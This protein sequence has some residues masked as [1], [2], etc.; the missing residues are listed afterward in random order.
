MVKFE[1]ES[2]PRHYIRQDNLRIKIAEFDINEMGQDD[3]SEV[4]FD[5]NWVPIL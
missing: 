3:I 4:D 5:T 1:S 2:C